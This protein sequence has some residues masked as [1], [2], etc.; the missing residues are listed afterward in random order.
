MNLQS[1]I[2]KVECS[3]D[4][5]KCNTTTMITGKKCRIMSVFYN[6]IFALVLDTKLCLISSLQKRKL[7]LAGKGMVQPRY[8]HINYLIEYDALL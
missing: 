3:D 5:D 1:A 2:V 6:L 4:I 7:G 8:K